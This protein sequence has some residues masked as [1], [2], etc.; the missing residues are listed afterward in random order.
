[1]SYNL[2]PKPRNRKTDYGHYTPRQSA[3]TCRGD[4]CKM[5]NQS[6]LPALRALRASRATTLTGIQNSTGRTIEPLITFWPKNRV[7]KLVYSGQT[8]TEH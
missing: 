5:G 2:N 8:C 1:M 6:W 4:S 3:E 7:T